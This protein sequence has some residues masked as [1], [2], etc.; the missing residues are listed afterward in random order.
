MQHH[1]TNLR[2][3]LREG[4]KDLNK[5][6]DELKNS[7]RETPVSQVCGK[8]LM[9][10]HEEDLCYGQCKYCLGWGHEPK[11][12]PTINQAF[13]DKI[14]AQKAKAKNTENKKA[15]EWCSQSFPVQKPHSN[16]IS[17]RWVTDFR[18]LNRALKRPV[19]G[20]KVHHKS[21]LKVK[22]Y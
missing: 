22:N 10:G 20:G 6:R 7:E 19:W 13:I 8:C 11:L 12:C 16:P 14:Q 18:N 3:V 21:N 15:S 1:Q 17:C 4:G 5:L 2:Q 9:W